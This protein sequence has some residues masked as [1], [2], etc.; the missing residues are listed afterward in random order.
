M[1]T[2]A[3]ENMVNVAEIAVSNKPTDFERYVELGMAYFHAQRL[4]DALVAFQRAIAL[5]PNAAS[6]YNGMG[7]VYYHTGPPEKAIAAY[8]RAIALDPH[9]VVAYYGLGILYSTKL[10][11]YE[12][13]L[14]VFQQGLEHNPTEAFLVA[15]L[16]STYARMGRFDEAI[17]TLQRA[18]HLQPDN[19]FAIEWL[20]LIALYQKRYDDVIAICQ[21]EIA[22]EDSD[23]PR[24]ILGYVYDRLGRHEEAIA[25][26]EQA[27]GFA[28]Q[29]YEARAALAKVYRRVGR[30]QDAQQHYTLARNLAR[31]DNEYGQACFEAVSGD[32]EASLTLL[33]V[34]LT[35][36]QV[37][38]GWLRID[39]EFTFMTDDL[40]FRALIE[41][42]Q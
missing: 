14:N 37:Q 23:E 8:Q 22:I 17:A 4:A 20:C 3:Q 15:S 10:G 42:E 39:P 28:P 1:H 21:R 38:K 19:T 33:K 24:R 41:D 27:V 16:G 25:Q 32:V 2:E 30:L 12:A 7:R 36:G 9:Y 11:N 13:A 29:D 34:A 31:Q 18:I 35:K 6:A 40:H 26:L 5:N